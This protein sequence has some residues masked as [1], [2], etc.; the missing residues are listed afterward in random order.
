MECFS[1]WQE[2]ET[3]SENKYKHYV[4]CLTLHTVVLGIVTQWVICLASRFVERAA[5]VSRVTFRWIPKW[6]GL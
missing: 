1:V 3:F 2:A 4:S 6:L 5:S